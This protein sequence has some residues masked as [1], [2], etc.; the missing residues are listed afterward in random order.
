MYNITYLIELKDKFTA[1]ASKINEANKKMR[2]QFKISNNALVGFGHNMRRM[3]ASITNVGRSLVVGITLPMAALGF[4]AIKTAAQLE[5]YQV[6]FE[7]MLKSQVKAKAL[8][9]DLIN[10]TAKTPF[11]IPEVAQSTKVLLAFGFSINEIVPKLQMLGNISA[12]VGI[13]IKDMAQIYGK[14]MALG[15]LQAKEIGQMTRRG[16]PIVA[17]LSKMLK[18]T[19]GDVFIM[20][21]KGLISSKIFNAALENLTK[22]G[23]LYYQGLIKQSRT[24][25]GLMSTLLDNINLTLG[26]IGAAYL[27]LLKKWAMHLITLTD[28]MR[29]MTD[30]QKRFYG[31]LIILG[32]VIPPIILLLGLMT[33]AI[34]SLA[35][36]IGFLTAPVA[37]PFALMGAAIAAVIGVLT[38][39]YL[40]VGWVRK[41]IQSLGVI[42]YGVFKLALYIVW[43]VIKAIALLA[44]SVTLFPLGGILKFIWHFK[45]AKAILSAVAILAMK[46]VNAIA[47]LSGI[48]AV[49]TTKEIKELEA[50]TKIKVDTSH[51]I[52]LNVKSDAN[53]SVSNVAVTAKKSS[54]S[55]RGSNALKPHSVWK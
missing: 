38:F 14:A 20:A 42:F 21:K 44:Y 24:F 50:N 35:M 25:N 32:I 47:K 54:V 29:A 10:F 31:T 41:L 52:D 28:K 30:G 39:L 2:D 40:K 4:Q 16:I 34:G 8:M 17:M 33:Q 26:S 37:L 48:N 7:I 9:K 11:R 49:F 55:P 46:A 23:G 6:S 1:V 43:Q 53:T 12:S 3:G 22:K 15:K 19:S 18:V 13:P 45:V 51:Q 27:P 36:A 5:Q